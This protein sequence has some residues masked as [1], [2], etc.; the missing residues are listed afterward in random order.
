M[1]WSSWVLFPSI[2]RYYRPP[3]LGI[4]SHHVLDT[5][6]IDPVLNIISLQ[7]LEVSPSNLEYHFPPVLGF[8]SLH[9]WLLS[10][11]TRGYH[12]LSLG[13][14]SLCWWASSSSV[15]EYHL[16]PVLCIN[17]LHLWMLSPSAVGYHLP[18]V[19]ATTSPIL[20]YLLPKSWL[21]FSS[22]LGYHFPPFLDIIFLHSL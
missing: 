12:L 19:K 5:I 10:P 20:R 18:P 8:I 14:M 22:I 11:S 17:T 7:S 6:I 3:F 1:Y 4:I 16:P 2:L 13:T 21:S 15:L 9:W